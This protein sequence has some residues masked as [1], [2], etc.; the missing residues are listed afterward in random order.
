MKNTFISIS[1]LLLAIPGF[2]LSATPGTI[3]L[4]QTGQTTCYSAAGAVVACAKTGQDGDLKAGAA[5]PN[6]RFQD[7]GDGTILDNLTNLI[8]AKQANTPGPPSCSNSQTLSRTSFAS[9]ITCLNTNAYLGKVDWRMP[10]IIELSSLLNLE[11]A[12]NVVWLKNQGFVGVADS[13]ASS[14]FYKGGNETNCSGR[15][16]YL[17]TY[18]NMLNLRTASISIQR[19]SATLTNPPITCSYAGIESDYIWP[20]RNNP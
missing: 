9:Y 20:V 4:P 12:D 5:I 11:Q 18:N 2:A 17:V 19:Y 15:D 6:P 8:W 14:T 7:L 16:T 1:M 3:Q 10:N 13:Y